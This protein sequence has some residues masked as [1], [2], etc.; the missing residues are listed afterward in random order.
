MLQITSFFSQ[1]PFCLLHMPYFSAFTPDTN[2]PGFVF[3]CSHFSTISISQPVFKVKL[4]AFFF[5]FLSVLFSRTLCSFFLFSSHS[6]FRCT[7]P[8]KSILLFLP[9]LDWSFL[10]SQPFLCSPTSFYIISSQFLLSLVI[11]FLC[12]LGMR[13][14][15]FTFRSRKQAASLL[16]SP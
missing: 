15:L 4:L 11:S 2:S 14:K 12:L 16:K 10:L 13:D 6:L 9:N 3:L 7:T 5:F 1:F 8:P